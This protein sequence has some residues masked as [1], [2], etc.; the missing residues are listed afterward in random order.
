MEMCD[1]PHTTS[2]LAPFSSMS[3]G[4]LGRALAKSER[5][6]PWTNVVPGSS[7]AASITACEEMSGS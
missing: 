6:R 3:I 4:L 7:T 5:S 2:S 1:E